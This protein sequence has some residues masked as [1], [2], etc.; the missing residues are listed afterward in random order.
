MQ[1]KE[2]YQGFSDEQ[3]E[4]YR[5]EVRQHWGEKTLEESEESILKMGTEK[6]AELQVEGGKIFQAISDNIP[7]G[8]E[9]RYSP[10]AGG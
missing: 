8:Y 9:K 6:F 7:E 5:Q 10:G 2:Y 1:I 3:I 4:K